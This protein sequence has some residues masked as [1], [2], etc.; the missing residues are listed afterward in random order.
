MGSP[1]PNPKS[2]PNP[3]PNQGGE[4]RLVFTEEAKA[5]VRDIARAYMHATFQKL[6]EQEP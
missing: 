3:N 4:L 2:N 5:G 1:N 6:D